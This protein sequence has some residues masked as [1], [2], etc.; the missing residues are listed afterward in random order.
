V[1]PLTI[2]MYQNAT[3]SET[4]EMNHDNATC[5]IMR[6]NF[7]KNSLESFFGSN[8][9]SSSCSRKISA[10]LTAAV[11]YSLSNPANT[12]RTVLQ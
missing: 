8:F 1:S 11:P 4:S 7:L 9:V 10:L 2:R 5:F 3:R 6:S 12:T